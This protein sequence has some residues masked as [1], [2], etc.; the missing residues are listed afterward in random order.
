MSTSLTLRYPR[1]EFPLTNTDKV[2]T[3]I[4]D[5][6]NNREPASI[7]RLGDGEG[8]VLA[9]PTPDEL[10]LWSHIESHFGPGVSTQFIE[11]LADKLTDAVDNADVVGIR[12]DLLNVDFQS[13]NFDLSQNE[14]TRQFKAMFN[15]RPVER[16]ITYPGAL[17]LAHTHHF[18][19]KHE[20]NKSTIFASAWLHFGLSQSGQLLKL[21]STQKSIGLISSKSGLVKQ[22][23]TN[24]DIKVNFHQIPDIYSKSAAIEDTSSDHQL[25]YILKHTLESLKV[26]F[27]GQLFLVGAGIYGK[28][29]CHKIK[30]LGGIAIDIGAVCDAWLSIPSRPLVFKALY[31][32]CGDTVPDCLRL[33]NQI[34][35]L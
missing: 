10:T 22:L 20:F 26:A 14:F 29:Y 5:R 34:K 31:D 17:R 3:F 25:P 1:C 30:S 27:Q 9:R 15:L 6:L 7:I 11:T 28:A 13:K 16:N 35:D 21:I 18:L 2:Y 32:G 12:D 4:S 33:M 8:M 23:E 19:A 24:L